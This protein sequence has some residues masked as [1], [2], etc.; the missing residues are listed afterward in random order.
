[1]QTIPEDFEEDLDGEMEE[2]EERAV[3]DALLEAEFHEN[4]VAVTEN[5]WFCI[6]LAFLC[7]KN[8][9]SDKN[10]WNWSPKSK[11]NSMQN[12][13]QF[14]PHKTIDQD[15]IYKVVPDVKRE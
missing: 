9:A 3:E 15:L 10:V 6:G 8:M 11:K 4:V 12:R 2:D 13:P 5:T 1:M 7:H 14:A